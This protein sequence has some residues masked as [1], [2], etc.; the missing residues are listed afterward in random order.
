[1]SVRVWEPRRRQGAWKVGHTMT[2][3]GW[4]EQESSHS[5]SKDGRAES[6]NGNMVLMDCYKGRTGTHPTPATSPQSSSRKKCLGREGWLDTFSVI[7][8]SKTH[9]QNFLI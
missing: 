8:S 6:Q 4:A 3:S 2:H 9:S 5:V 7:S 1:M